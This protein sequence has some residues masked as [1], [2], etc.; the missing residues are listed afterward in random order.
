MYSS[1]RDHSTTP[2][3][4][5]SQYGMQVQALGTIVEGLE[6]GDMT[7][8]KSASNISLGSAQGNSEQVIP[9]NHN[10]S[11]DPALRLQ[12][13]KQPTIGE[14]PASMADTMLTNR[15]RD[16]DIFFEDEKWVFPFDQPEMPPLP[17][18]R[19]DERV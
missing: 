18:V 2:P 10:R 19:N 17:H 3:S 8:E 9:P 7:P 16:I 5:V 15:S 6:N 4:Y 12:H 14:T 13:A 1:N 11:N